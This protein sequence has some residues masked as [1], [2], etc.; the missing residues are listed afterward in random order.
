MAVNDDDCRCSL[1]L[2]VSDEGLKDV[3]E[4]PNVSEFEPESPLP[5]TGF[6][7]F[8]RLCQILGSIH[9]LQSPSRIAKL[10]TKKGSQKLM[11]SVK[12]LDYSLSHWLEN[13][14]DSIRF[15]AK[16]ISTSS[17][18]TRRD[19]QLIGINLS[20]MDCGPNM[21]MSAIMFIVHAGSLLNL[22]RFE[23]NRCI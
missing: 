9:G 5:L 12:R 3:C 10:K 13:A 21:T 2:P 4:K 23:S 1:P 7:A 8:A 11:Q 20:S 6:I 14:P 16:Y 18:Y 22:Y 15:A 19:P 17:P